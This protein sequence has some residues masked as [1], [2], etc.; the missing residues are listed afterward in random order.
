MAVL[1][2]ADVA[3]DVEVP[4]AIIGAGACGQIAALTA[5]DAGCEVLVLE[6]DAAPQGSTALSS[7]MIPACETAVQKRMGIDDTVDILTADVMAKC[8]DEADPAVVAAVCRESGPAIDWLI[9]AHGVELTVVEGSLYSG[10][11]RPRMHAPPSR[12]GAELIGAITRATE[13]TAASLALRTTAETTGVEKDKAAKI[14][15]SGRVIQP[16]SESCTSFSHS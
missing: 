9:E 5:T 10:H 7:G 16:V 13:D 1:D 14:L 3:F 15:T 8:H 6:R 11:S 4:V 12:T 2:A